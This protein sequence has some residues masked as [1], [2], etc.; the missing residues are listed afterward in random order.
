MR[1][2]SLRSF[3]IGRRQSDLIFDQRAQGVSNGQGPADK[4]LHGALTCEPLQATGMIRC[5]RMVVP[6]NGS[7]NLIMIRVDP[8]GGVVSGRDTAGGPILQP[9]QLAQPASD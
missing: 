3:P 2:D 5:Q 6:A 9:A 4:F 7:S 8:A 1:Q